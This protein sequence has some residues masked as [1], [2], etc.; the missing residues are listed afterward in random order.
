MNVGIFLLCGR[1]D[2]TLN[3]K[4]FA[5]DAKGGFYI[6]DV[7]KTVIIHPWCDG[8]LFLIERVYTRGWM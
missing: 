8:R 1:R 2:F 4:S 5:L 3:E 7:K 6:L